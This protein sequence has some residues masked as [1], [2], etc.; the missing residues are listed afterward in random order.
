[1]IMGNVVV[2]VVGAWQWSR[3]LVVE[4]N[5]ED[6]FSF[7]FFLL[8]PPFDPR[9]HD[10]RSLSSQSNLRSTSYSWSWWWWLLLSPAVSH[11]ILIMIVIITMIEFNLSP[12]FCWFASNQIIPLN[13][14]IFLRRRLRREWMNIQ[15]DF[16]SSWWFSSRQ[17]QFSSSFSSHHHDRCD[18]HCFPSCL[19]VG[20]LGIGQKAC[21]FKLFGAGSASFSFS[22][23]LFSP[24]THSPT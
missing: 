20:F 14:F 9:R 19:S 8:F 18:D 4:S 24:E 13:Y 21:A 3:L 16:I 10:A 7:G 17:F 5:K 23:S 6:I 12:S 11:Q 15:R 22:L 2:V 1:M